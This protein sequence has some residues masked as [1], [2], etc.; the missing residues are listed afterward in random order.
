M[1]S[2]DY[3]TRLL[4]EFEVRY[5]PL[6]IRRP[7]RGVE[8]IAV[9]CPI[10]G[11]AL[12]VT[13]R[14]RSAVRNRRVAF[15]IAGAA[16]AL[17]CFIGWLAP[18]GSHEGGAR[19]E[20]WSFLWLALAVGALRLLW[21]AVAGV[22][23]LA[24][25]ST[26]VPDDRHAFEE[27]PVRVSAAAA[28]PQ[29]PTA[30]GE[31]P[32]AVA[33]ALRSDRRR[34]AVIASSFVVGAVALGLVAW[35]D[36]S[37]S[38]GPGAGFRWSVTLLAAAFLASALPLA[39]IFWRRERRAR[40]ALFERRGEVEWIRARLVV[41]LATKG[42]VVDG[43]FELGS[44]AGSPA[45]LTLPTNSTPELAEAVRRGLESWFAGVEWRDERASE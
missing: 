31:L 17:V 25:E 20:V 36:D 11:A 12:T 39:R 29:P 41:Q 28:E 14:S 23:W 2:A 8:R 24:V 16:A 3:G 42:R 13:A 19:S 27:P 18:F 44:R 40:A 30:A 38:G 43:H 6:P 34:G 21:G 1:A 10:C 5:V 26:V 32:E 35:F 45:R 15:G 37:S 22:P 33:R 7:A 4:T 9:E